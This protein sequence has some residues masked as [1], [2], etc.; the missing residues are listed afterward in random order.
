MPLGRQQYDELTRW[1]TETIERLSL[2]ST[3]QV[4]RRALV[5]GVNLFVATASP[6][7]R[8]PRR[9]GAAGRSWPAGIR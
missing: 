1:T 4:G 8:A 3:R 7:S 5:I 2:V 9:K 6:R